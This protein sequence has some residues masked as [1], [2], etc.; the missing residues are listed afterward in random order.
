MGSKHGIAVAGVLV[1][2]VGSY[3]LF[4]NPAPSETPLGGELFI[5]NVTG[6][7][8]GY[9][10]ETVEL[11]I[12]WIKGGDGNFSGVFMVGGL[13]PCVKARGIG[14]MELS[15][16]GELRE[17]LLSIILTLGK[18][19]RCVLD[20]AYVELLQGNR[21]KRV[22]LGRVEFVILKPE[23]ER[24]VITRY[25][26][27]FSGS[28]PPRKVPFRYT[29]FNPLNEPVEV[30][31]VTFNLSDFRLE[32][33]RPVKILPNHMANITFTLVNTIKPGS[34]Y[35]IRPILVYRVGSE[36]H[37]MPAETYYLDTIPDDE[38]LKKML[39]GE[40]P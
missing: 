18:P 19:G 16:R 35:V 2:L 11:H 31:N 13:P 40:G 24:P 1:L 5:S 15:Q 20:G 6:Y 3:L 33:F 36:T 4:N 7:I 30:L 32:G 12:Y 25:I 23:A 26:S 29:L 14:L 22:P 8:A 39:R 38:T 34:L 9:P 21:S 27:G 28:E 17:A 10:N 37:V